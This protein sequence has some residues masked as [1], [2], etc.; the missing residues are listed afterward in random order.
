MVRSFLRD[1]DL[2]PAEAAEVFELAHRYK[3]LR[4]AGV[5]DVLRGQSWGLV[6]FKKS[7]RTRL[8]FEAGIYELGG[9][10]MVLQA[11]DLQI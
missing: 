5:L 3:K 10:P 11:D 2:T 6:F 8:S 4:P 1:T 7:T 9:N